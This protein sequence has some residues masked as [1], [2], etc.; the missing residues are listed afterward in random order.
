[1]VYAGFELPKIYEE[2]TLENKDFG[3]DYF[4]NRPDPLKEWYGNCKA[5]YAN[6]HGFPI[7]PWD[8]VE[9][10]LSE[11]DTT[12]LHYVLVPEDI[13]VV[14][15]DNHGGSDFKEV[16]PQLDKL[17]ASYAEISKSG[18]GIHVHYQVHSRTK[19]ENIASNIEVKS[20]EGHQSLRR[21]YTLSN[22]LDI[23]KNP[24]ILI[25][26]N[27]VETRTE[28]KNEKMLRALMKK[29]LNKEIHANTKP[30]VDF[31]MHILKRANIELPKYDVRDLYDDVRMFADKSSNHPY[32]WQDVDVR[33]FAKS[34]IQ[35]IFQDAKYV[36]YDVE[37]A[38]NK[39]MI[40]YAPITEE[41][42][43]EILE[44]GIWDFNWD[45]IKLYSILDPTPIDIVQLVQNPL[46]GFN[47][48]QY[49]DHILDAIMANKDAEDVYLTSQQIIEGNNY[50]NYKN[51]W[52]DV[53][54][55]INIKKGVKRWQAEGKIPFAH[56]ELGLPWDEPIL[57]K[58][59]DQWVAYCEHDVKSQLAILY[60]NWH[61][62]EAREYLSE[63]SELPLGYPTNRHVYNILTDGDNSQLV[64]TDLS[65]E[66]PGYT[67]YVDSFTGK[68]KSE[69]K[70]VDPSEGGYVYTEPGYYENVVAL[71][72]SGM[73]PA[74]AIALD[75]FGPK[76]TPIFKDMVDNRTRYKDSKD[77]KEKIK[78]YGLK[79][80][81]N[82]VYGLTS[83]KFDNPLRHPLNDDNIIAKRGALFMIDWKEYA[84]SIGL[85]VIH[86]KTDCIKIID[87]T[88]EQVE[89]M[90]EFAVKYGYRADIEGIY[91]QF[92]LLNKAFYIGYADDHVELIGKDFISPMYVQKR[93]KGEEILPEDFGIM[94]SV[95][96][97][98][99]TLGDFT[100]RTA[101]IYAS[102]TGYD[103]TNANGKG[104]IQG[105]KGYL[106]RR[107][108]EF[109]PDDLNLE[110][111]EE[112]Y[113]KQLQKMEKLK[114]GK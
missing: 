93:F 66:F 37:V 7:L 52:L 51:S 56:K 106:W 2:V 28:I 26:R 72:I 85:H 103:C 96:K 69:Y 94:V 21:Q 42:H 114:N 30:N 107:M 25:P 20:L 27:E 43:N 22:G 15:I 89:L 76:Y 98:Q 74:S 110:Y 71:D 41:M 82:S 45:K 63:L 1:M 48:M 111:Y 16:L 83:A 113:Y 5:Q 39:N 46:V 84:E 31:I 108:D 112:K 70:G 60:L 50:R 57:E 78:A 32:L 73:H 44:K 67:W 10:T 75:Y 62:V 40:S 55:V 79:I 29:A 54:D 61:D 97:G 12:K 24:N 90:K 6:E 53:Y 3:S 101:Y 64:Y 9:T 23:A 65:E 19:Y 59:I 34:G 104:F 99:I 17:P 11:L 49:D 88:D 105:T 4:L 102:K 13:V 35:T 18:T 8:K 87:P 14:D 33:L 81:N 58:H 68:V 109:T 86:I 80:I 95:N 91:R 36:M 47:N 38:C 100:G 92:Y 77:P